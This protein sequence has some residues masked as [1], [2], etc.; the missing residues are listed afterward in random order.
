MNWDPDKF[1]DEKT[2]RYEKTKDFAGHHKEM[3][4]H[5]VYPKSK[6]TNPNLLFDIRLGPSAKF[7]TNDPGDRFDANYDAGG[8]MTPR[9]KKLKNDWVKSGGDTVDFDQKFQDTMKQFEFIEAHNENFHQWFILDQYI[10][11]T[12]KIHAPLSDAEVIALKTLSV[13]Y[14]YDKVEDKQIVQLEG[15]GVPWPCLT[16]KQFENSKTEAWSKVK[17]KTD[18]FNRIHEVLTTVEFTEKSQR[19]NNR[20][21]TRGSITDLSLVTFLRKKAEV[22]NAGWACFDDLCWAPIDKSQTPISLLPRILNICYYLEDDLLGNINISCNELKKHYASDDKIEP[23]SSGKTTVIYIDDKALVDAF[24]WFESI[25][26]FRKHRLKFK[27][28][29]SGDDKFNC[30]N[31]E[32]DAKKALSKE[33]SDQYVQSLKIQNKKK[34]ASAKLEAEKEFNSKVSVYGSEQFNALQAK[35]RELSVEKLKKALDSCRQFYA[36][37]SMENRPFYLNIPALWFQLDNRVFNHVKQLINDEKQ[38]WLYTADF[39]G[40]IDRQ[41]HNMEAAKGNL[42]NTISQYVKTQISHLYEHID[43]VLLANASAMDATKFVKD[44]SPLYPV[45]TTDFWQTKQNDATTAPEWAY[46]E[47]AKNRIGIENGGNSCYLAALLNVWAS[48]VVLFNLLTT[49][50]IDGNPQQQL[51]Q[52][53][54]IRLLPAIRAR[55]L[56]DKNDINDFRQTLTRLGL[57]PPSTLPVAKGED[58]YR[59]YAQQD[60]SEVMMEILALLFPGPQSNIQLL[61]GTS[62]RYTKLT[63]DQDQNPADLSTLPDNNILV[64]QPQRQTFLNLPVTANLQHAVNSY[65]TEKI[66]NVRVIKDHQ[67]NKATVIRKSTFEHPLPKTL[68]I[69]LNRFNGDLGK[70]STPV[71]VPTH[72]GIDHEHGSYRL[73]SAIIHIGTSNRSGHYTALTIDPENIDHCTLHDDAYITENPENWQ[74]MMQHSYCLFYTLTHEF[75]LEVEPP[76][77]NNPLIAMVQNKPGLPFNGPLK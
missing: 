45:A 75:N 70:D 43:V 29:Y 49:P 61:V 59:T 50:I 51:V 77:S 40:D 28:C 74:G 32:H 41:L 10:E 16:I 53:H 68:C 14:L 20:W 30:K 22:E 3:T 25:L 46:Q 67:V 33:Y 57:M 64:R 2:E 65:T 72:L 17:D 48:N 12:L 73:Q 44:P 69:L 71:T 47:T 38:R 62:D 6:T 76:I 21:A 27:L 7:R 4:W 36:A 55:R 39:K 26:Y 1:K 11:T 5:H 8:E 13:G 34:I 35:C 54:L 42:S 63:L 19:I 15:S 23:E 52:R 31:F 60:P 24:Y 56:I 18:L 37:P 9:S 66:E 58:D